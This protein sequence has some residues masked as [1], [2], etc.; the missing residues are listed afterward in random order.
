LNAAEMQDK[1]LVEAK[2]K[3]KVAKMAF[4]LVG[5]K[6]DGSAENLVAWLVDLLELLKVD[7]KVEKK[8]VWKVESKEILS[9]LLLAV[10]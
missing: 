10:L 7:L 1:L 8:A 4:H 2:D 5:M 6:V 9:V 3:L